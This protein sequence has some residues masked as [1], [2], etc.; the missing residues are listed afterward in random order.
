MG[1]LF[2]VQE[3]TSEANFTH[4]AHTASISAVATSE[5]FVATG[6]KDET[7][8]LYDMKNRIEHGALLQHDGEWLHSWKCLWLNPREVTFYMEAPRMH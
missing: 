5:R 1:F 8:Q 6:S 4:H 3:W 2:V 7:I